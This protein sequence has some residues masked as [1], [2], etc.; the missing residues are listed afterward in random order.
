MVKLL[1]LLIILGL[2]IQAL[3]AGVLREGM[4]REDVEA[5]LGRPLSVME[6]GEHVVLLFAGGLKVELH[7]GKVVDMSPSLRAP[8]VPEPKGPPPE[9]TLK[10]VLSQELKRPAEMVDMPPPSAVQKASDPEAGALVPARA[11]KDLPAS[12]SRRYEEPVIKFWIH[13]LLSSL[14]NFVITLAALRL[15]FRWVDVQAEWGHLWLPAL[16]EVLTRLGVVLVALFAFGLGNVF[17]IDEAVSL[18]VLIYLLKRATFACT[19][20]RAVAVAFAAK[21]TGFVLWAF[22]SAPLMRLVGS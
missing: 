1:R 5:Q 11:G 6:K 17:G 13:L 3:L 16:G 9:T 15:A 19:L 21:T 8:E 20:P 2:C 18:L 7:G 14:V 4:N 12:A 22:A 10:D